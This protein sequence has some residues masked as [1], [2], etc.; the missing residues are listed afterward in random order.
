MSPVPPIAPSG[1]ALGFLRANRD[2]EASLVRAIRPRASG[3]V[4]PVT[5]CL[6]Y[7]R[8]VIPY[9][10]LSGRF[11]VKETLLFCGGV[12]SPVTSCLRYHRIVIPYTR[13]SGRFRV[14]DTL[15][16]CG[17]VASPVGSCLRPCLVVIPNIHSNNFLRVSDTL[18]FCG[19]GARRLRSP[20][21]ADG[22]ALRRSSG[23]AAARATSWDTFRL[24]TGKKSR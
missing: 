22:V 4:S 3:I 23:S 17:G 2:I 13:L 15:L 14:K 6:R 12:A 24:A 19:S 5:S 11:R 8:I 18:A 20:R 16:F 1:Q 7:Y 21:A 9:T 10:R